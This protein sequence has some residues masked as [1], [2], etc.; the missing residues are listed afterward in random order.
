MIKEQCVLVI[1]CLSD[2]TLDSLTTMKE[3]SQHGGEFGGN[4]VA[5]LMKKRLT[6]LLLTA[7]LLPLVAMPGRNKRRRHIRLTP[8]EAEEPVQFRRGQDRSSTEA[9]GCAGRLSP[10][11]M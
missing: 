5:V 10:R 8:E 3:R 9:A 6:L 11:G 1:S 4:V 7:L 2:P